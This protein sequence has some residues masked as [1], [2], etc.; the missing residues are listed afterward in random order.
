MR[1]RAV[2]AAVALMMLAACA[3]KV[4]DPVQARGHA[5]REYFP[6]PFF[7]VWSWSYQS[8]ALTPIPSQPGSDLDDN[9]YRQMRQGENNWIN[10][11]APWA[12]THPGHLYI[13]GDEMDKDGWAQE[14]RYDPAGYGVKY[15]QAVREISDPNNGDIYAKFSPSGFNDQVSDWYIN[16]FAASVLSEYQNGNCGTNPISEWTFHKFGDWGAGLGAFE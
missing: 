1:T 4:V 12:R 15:C 7:M 11:T 5:A 10:D 13:I 16:T 3:E 8:D 6:D 14:F 2:A 9:V